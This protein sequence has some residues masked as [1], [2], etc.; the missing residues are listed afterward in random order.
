MDSNNW[1]KDEEQIVIFLKKLKDDL[2]ISFLQSRAERNQGDDMSEESLQIELELAVNEIT[3]KEEQL[4][5]AVQ[6][7]CKIERIK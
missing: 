7:G 1:R 4:N 2:A 5:L 6:L 3:G